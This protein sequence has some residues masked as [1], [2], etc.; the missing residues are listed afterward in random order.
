MRA[1]KRN[2]ELGNCCLKEVIRQL[3]TSEESLV[4]EIHRTRLYTY[5]LHLPVLKIS[6]E[7]ISHPPPE[8][9]NDNNYIKC[10]LIRYGWQS[11]IS[12][13]HHKNNLNFMAKFPFQHHRQIYYT[14]IMLH[15]LISCS[16]PLHSVITNGWHLITK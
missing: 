11:S 15:T 16:Y 9:D 3:N 12:S 4:T 5:L 8:N 7:I 10:S 13:T 14:L 2:V 6:I 1:S